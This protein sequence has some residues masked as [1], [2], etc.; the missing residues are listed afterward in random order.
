MKRFFVLASL[1][2]AVSSCS[3]QNSEGP[4]GEPSALIL[5]GQIDIKKMAADAQPT[6]ADNNALPATAIGV[7]VLTVSG[8]GQT[9]FVTTTW[10]NKSF[11][12]D[13]AGVISG[14]DVTL[15]TGTSYDVY[16]YAPRVDGDIADVHAIPVAHG[17]DILWVPK[18]NAVAKAGGTQVALQFQHCGAQIGF[19]L[20]P[21][22]GVTN[23]DN[24]DLLVEGFYKTGTLNLET[25]VVTPS[26]ATQSVT[27]KGSKKVNILVNGNEMTLTVTVSNVPGKTKAFTGTIKKAFQSGSSYLYDVNLSLEGGDPITFKPHITDWTNVNSSEI[28][29]Q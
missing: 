21:S 26:D 9:D 24:V 22:D 8:S 20:V 18:H 19:N 16:A 11:V 13:A 10:K 25:G 23:L 2:L 4:G 28:P 1:I 15:R 3:K 5:N 12:S 14:G 7:Y 17:V 27:E 6:R 29:A